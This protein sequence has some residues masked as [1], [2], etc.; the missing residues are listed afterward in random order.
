VPTRWSAAAPIR[1]RAALSQN[2]SREVPVFWTQAS[3]KRAA[4]AETVQNR[5]R[6]VVRRPDDALRDSR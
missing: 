3:A 1:V 4:L 5:G 6:L 2:A